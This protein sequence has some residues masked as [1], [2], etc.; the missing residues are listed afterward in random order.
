M[1]IFTKANAFVNGALSIAVRHALD[2]AYEQAQLYEYNHKNVRRKRA[3]RPVATAG[4]GRGE[5][6]HA[7]L[8]S[9]GEQIEA[10]LRE[11]GVT[12]DTLKAWQDA[13]R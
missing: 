6:L 10:T 4:I 12:P 8:M 1:T 9:G 11:M 13:Q 7:L 5:L 3:R 2:A